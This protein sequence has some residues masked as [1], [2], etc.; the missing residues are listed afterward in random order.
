VN[1]QDYVTTTRFGGRAQS[2]VLNFLE[3]LTLGRCCPEA[4]YRQYCE[5]SECEHQARRLDRLL[6]SEITEV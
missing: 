5:H 1:E 3:S 2:I 6:C 4:C